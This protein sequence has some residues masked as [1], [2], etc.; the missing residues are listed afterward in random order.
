MLLT[1]PNLAAADHITLGGSEV[2]PDGTFR[3]G[4]VAIAHT[5]TGYQVRGPPWIGGPADDSEM[6][7]AFR[8]DR[9][10]ISTVWVW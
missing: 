8:F 10:A 3:P 6:N 4:T 9:R 1:A 5:G 2:N 7:A